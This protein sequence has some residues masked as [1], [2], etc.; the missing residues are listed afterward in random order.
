MGLGLQAYIDDNGG[1]FPYAGADAYH[2]HTPGVPPW[3]MGGSSTCWSAIKKYVKNDEVRWCPLYK[4]NYPANYKAYIAN[5]TTAKY[6]W[7]YWYFCGHNNVWVTDY[8]SPTSGPELC[9]YAMSDV[10]YA[11]RKPSIVEVGSIHARGRIA[12][13]YWNPVDRFTYGIAFVDGH[14]KMLNCT[15]KTTILYAYTRRDGTEPKALGANHRG[16]ITGD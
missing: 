1:R 4:A 16:I 13:Q 8:D 14:A 6:A 15:A 12:G 2:V 11:S 7:S 3:G 10:K 9:G 5:S